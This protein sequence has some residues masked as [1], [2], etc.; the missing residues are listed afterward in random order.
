MA[1]E[2]PLQDHMISDAVV[3]VALRD[4]HRFVNPNNEL[5]QPEDK[6]YTR[7]ALKLLHRGRHRLVPEELAEW[8]LANGWGPVAA[9]RLRAFAERVL[10]GRSFVYKSGIGRGFTAETLEAWRSAAAHEVS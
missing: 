2:L 6:D 1:R 10:E 7:A 9:K 3:R 5:A 8:A 4:V